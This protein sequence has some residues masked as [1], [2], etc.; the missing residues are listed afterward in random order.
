M[1]GSGENRQARGRGLREGGERLAPS[2][3]CTSVAKWPLSKALN[4]GGSRQSRVSVA[5]TCFIPFHCSAN[6]NLF[7]SSWPGWSAGKRFGR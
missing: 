5:D 2:W 3:L 7:V 6:A 1:V 4:L